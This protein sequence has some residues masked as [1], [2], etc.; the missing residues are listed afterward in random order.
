MSASRKTGIH[1]QLVT[2][3]VGQAVFSCLPSGQAKRVSEHHSCSQ[4]PMVRGHRAGCLPGCAPQRRACPPTPAACL[5]SSAG[6]GR[7]SGQRAGGRAHLTADS[8]LPQQTWCD[9]AA[10]GSP[11]RQQAA[12]TAG[13]TGR[14]G[15]RCTRSSPG[16][17]TASAQSC[18]GRRSAVRVS[19]AQSIL[20]SLH[21]QLSHKEGAMNR[22]R[23]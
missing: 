9:V 12:Q 18:Q 2:L 1:E 13:D 22:L 20:I 15:R 3:N 11:D 23:V 4:G 7:H 21:G 16:R 6:P 5:Q 19:E 17:P 10:M 8:T 14:D